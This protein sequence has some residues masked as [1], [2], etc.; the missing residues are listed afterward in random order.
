MSVSTAVCELLRG[1]NCAL[2]CFQSLE[3]PSI[4][5]QCSKYACAVN[6]LIHLL[7]G[8]HEEKE[9]EVKR[10]R[11]GNGDQDRCWESK[12]TPETR[13]FGGHHSTLT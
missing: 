5:K 13:A 9:K 6:Q 3:Q 12:N 7:M 8:Q 1:R 2:M 4:H 10:R 11:E